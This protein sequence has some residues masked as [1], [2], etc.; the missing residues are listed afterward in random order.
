[1]AILLI[2]FIT[3]HNLWRLRNNIVSMLKKCTVTDAIRKELER[4]QMGPVMY[5]FIMLF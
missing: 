4:E 3:K 1:M 5:K 2:I